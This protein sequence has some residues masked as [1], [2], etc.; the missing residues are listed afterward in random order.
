MLGFVLGHLQLWLKIRFTMDCVKMW[1]YL[2]CPSDRPTKNGVPKKHV[3]VDREPEHDAQDFLLRWKKSSIY[4][5]LLR[6]KNLLLPK[7]LRVGKSEIYVQYYTALQYPTFCVFF[8]VLSNMLYERRFGPFFVNP[9]V[10]GLDP[11]TSEPY[12]CGMDLIGCKN[13]PPDFA[14]AGTCEEQL[15]GRCLWECF[16]CVKINPVYK[17]ITTTMGQALLWR[18]IWQA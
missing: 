12:V 13:E 3:R 4:I 9:V 8:T 11:E 1:S 18:S 14:V 5:F 15:F 2:C 7:K 6:I 10:A 17:R 16:Q